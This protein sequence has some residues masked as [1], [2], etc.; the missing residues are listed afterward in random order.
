MPFVYTYVFVCGRM[1]KG[2]SRKEVFDEMAF[3]MK[4]FAGSLQ[5]S[6]AFAPQMLRV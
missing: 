2:G 1:A 6:P 4:L 3:P 5:R